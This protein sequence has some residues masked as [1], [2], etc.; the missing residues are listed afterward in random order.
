MNLFR[1]YA[2]Q[3]V[4]ISC[5]AFFIFLAACQEQKEAAPKQATDKLRI[6]TSFRV[7]SLEP[8]RPASYFL[9][10]F[11]LA[12]L[13][14]MLS[15]A[16]RLEPNLLESY[17]RID[18]R[19][20]RLV[21]RPNIKFQ[22]GKPLTAVA[23]ASA[24]NRQLER[25]TSAKAVLPG[26]KVAVTSERELVLI[27]AN[28]DPTVP[29]ALADELV[30]PIYD[31]EA[32]E[33]A[34]GD[35]I[36]LIAGGCF[37]GPYRAVS[38]D[39]RELRMIRFDEYWQGRPPLSQVSVRFI[40]DPQARVL[41]VQNDEADIALYPPSEAQQMLAGAGGAF[42]VTNPRS[43]GG[44][45]IF[46]NIRQHPF[47]EI[48]PRRAFSFGINYESLARDVMEGIGET[49]TGFYPPV[50]PWA[51]QNQKSNEAEA[52]QLLDE[53]GWRVGGDG[54]R[55]KNGQALEVTLLVYPQQPDWAKLATAMQAQL[56]EVGF[57]LRIR[58]VEDINAAMK[59]QTG[60]H[61]AINSPG[62]VTTGGAPDPFLR[63]HL[64]SRGERN[65]GGVSDTELDRLLNELSSTFDEESRNEILR[66][67]QQILMVEK[68]YEVRPV[69][70]RSRAVVGKRWRHYQPSPQLHHITWETKSD[71]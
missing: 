12:E 24:M 53:A 1:T 21:L 36:K 32:V 45:R 35:N 15:A 41:A 55:V 61:A 40:G 28:P 42:F 14:L 6:V 63:E 59:S 8:V 38:L 22:N 56:R 65:F 44:P 13:P 31:V 33:A 48:A 64:Y 29:A 26:A 19:N 3:A 66:R 54:V 68:I 9:I 37:T 47:D 50:Y 62:L 69:F 34:N 49:A 18:E 4:R 11:A 58:Q 25:S 39:E 52:K 27:T 70:L 71:H 43:H 7:Q 30:F 23:M 20:W 10:E 67:L 57:R 60:W 2:K 5:F 16:G 46:L 51:V 17:S